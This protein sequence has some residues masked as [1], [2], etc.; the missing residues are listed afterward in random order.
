MTDKFEKFIKSRIIE[1]K[2]DCSI[3]YRIRNDVF[4]LVLIEYRWFLKEQKREK[5]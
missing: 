4:R 2:D 1:E 3:A 5:G